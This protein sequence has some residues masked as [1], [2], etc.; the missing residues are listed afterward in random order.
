M[1]QRPLVGLGTLLEAGGKWAES[2]RAGARGCSDVMWGVESCRG[3]ASALRRAAAGGALWK[4]LLG[5][6]LWPLPP[7]ASPSAATTR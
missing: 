4:P 7:P 5:S 1:P 2:R 6:R 3:G